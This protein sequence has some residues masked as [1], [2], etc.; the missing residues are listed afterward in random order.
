MKKVKFTKKLKKQLK[1]LGMIL[2]VPDN[3]RKWVNPN[4]IFKLPCDL[5]N[6]F[7]FANYSE[8]GHFSSIASNAQNRTD[9]ILGD[10]CVVS[11]AILGV[12]THPIDKTG[13]SP[14]FYS[15]NYK[16]NW[17]TNLEMEEFTKERGQKVV[18]GDNCFVG[19]YALIFAG[20]TLEERSYITQQCAIMNNVKSGSIMSQC[21]DEKTGRIVS[22]VTGQTRYTGNREVLDSFIKKS[23]DLGNI[24]PIS[25]ITGQDIIN[26]ANSW[27]NRLFFNHL[28][29]K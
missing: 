13:C 24:P 6:D 9:L 8:I 15:K 14:V 19:I 18:I 12:G 7:N 5:S 2:G 11:D 20:V 21:V 22:K 27:K 1:S 23:Y 16:K 28:N 3:K 29:L 10:F 26:M 4:S 17:N 25:F